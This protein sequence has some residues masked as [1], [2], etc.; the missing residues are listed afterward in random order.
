MAEP[1]PGRCGA[2]LRGKPGCFCKQ[3][4]ITGRTRCKLHGGASLQGFEHPAFTSG[5][6]TESLKK[7]GLGAHYEAARHDPAL[8]SLT[9]EITVVQGRLFE[10]FEQMAQG[11]GGP[12]AWQRVIGATATC[13][14]AMQ[15]V[16]GAVADRSPNRGVLMAQALTALGVAIDA[17]AEVVKQGT[18]VVEVWQEI[19]QKMYLRKK[20]VDSE[21]KRRKAAAEVLLKNDAL[22][23]VTRIAKSVMQHVTDPKAKQAIVN[24]IRA[25][26]QGEKKE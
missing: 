5:R 10:L 14:D 22:T 26:M 23:M 8:L 16:K 12:T 1:I 7:L 21:V 2:Q 6:Y 25:L 3:Y 13:A 24:D 15:A 20:L 19:D 9:E 17:L 18:S 11:A 4:P